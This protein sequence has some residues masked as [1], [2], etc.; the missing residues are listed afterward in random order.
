MEAPACGNCK[1]FR[2]GMNGTAYG[3]C[4]RFPMP[5]THDKGHWC[6]E[7][8]QVK[9]TQIKEPAKGKS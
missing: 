4:V 6:G 3:D 9:E 7:Y 8:V 5:V 2:Q 1:F